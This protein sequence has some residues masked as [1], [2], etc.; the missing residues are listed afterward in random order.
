MSQRPH[1]LRGTSGAIVL[2]VIL[3]RE[4]Q[5]NILNERTV[6]SIGSLYQQLGP[7][8]KGTYYAF[9]TFMT[10]QRCYND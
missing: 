10:Y 3:L 6:L 4:I 5:A 7:S 2:S 9:W 1:G 8:L